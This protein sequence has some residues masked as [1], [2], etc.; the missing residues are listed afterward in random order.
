MPKPLT[1]DGTDDSGL[2]AR[3]YNWS[4][5]EGMLDGSLASTNH[6][7]GRSIVL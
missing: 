7:N 3:D 4:N 6:D 1:V 5:R 2:E